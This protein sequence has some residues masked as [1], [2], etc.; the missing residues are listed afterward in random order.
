MPW[1]DCHD[2]D[3]T[4]DSLADVIGAS[5]GEVER[6]LEEHD[7]ARFDDTA[8]DPGLLMPRDVLGHFAADLD[9]VA[10]RF[11][12]AYY[13]HGTRAVD[14]KAFS[15]R[16]ILPLD[17]VL[18]ELW[19]TLRELARDEVLAEEWAAFRHGVETGN[20]GDD[21]W[22]YRHKVGAGVDRGPFG[23]VVRDILLEP[24][25]TGSHD[26]LGCPEIVQDIARCF[27]SA[28]SVNL[29]QRFCDAAKP[30]IVKF[31]STLLRPGA[32]KAALWYAYT[33]LRDGEITRNSNYS[34][35]GNGEAVPAEDVLT[36][37][38][39]STIY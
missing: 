29:E 39:L 1:L 21:G 23:L 18:E 24:Q 34:F 28:R 27:S 26:Y 32:I 30:C 22:L 17:Q 14:P 36:I 25:S 38:I 7:E 9:T 10:G 37:E 11:D 13:F 8:E 15:L 5:S 2:L 20:G 6:V 19:A 16:G 31:R 35:D 3:S 12:G 33:K 4:V